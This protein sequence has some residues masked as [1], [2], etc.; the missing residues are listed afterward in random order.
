MEGSY[1]RI[2][3]TPIKDAGITPKIAVFTRM[4]YGKNIDRERLDIHRN[5]FLKSLQKQIYKNFDVYIITGGLKYESAPDNIKLIEAQ[6]PG[7]LNIFYRHFKDIPKNVYNIQIRVDDDD[8][9][10]PMFI[11]KCLDIYSN[12]NKNIFIITFRPYK[13][14]YKN[15]KIYKIRADKYSRNPSMF[16]AL[17]Q[18][19]DIKHFIYDYSHSKLRKI[20]KKTI[21][22]EEGYCMLTIH[23]DNIS[24]EMKGTD[25]YLC[26]ALI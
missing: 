26:N 15:N 7:G 2:F 20:T 18:K 17:C 9:L 24:S 22:V 6:N 14:D 23:K 11:L 4:E 10:S 8:Y 16:S 5:L 13:Y 12:T 3:K 1:M 25:R 21:F 19:T